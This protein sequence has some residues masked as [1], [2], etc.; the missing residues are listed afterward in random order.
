MDTSVWQPER[1]DFA[2]PP[3][4]EDGVTRPQIAG[5]IYGQQ[6]GLFDLRHLI[7]SATPAVRTAAKPAAGRHEAQPKPSAA[8]AKEWAA[9]RAP[10]LAQARG[11]KLAQAVSI[12]ERATLHCT[13]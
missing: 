9:D 5:V 6:D 11:I 12:L 8:K 7:D 2:G 10:A 13:C 3:I 1:L 4:L